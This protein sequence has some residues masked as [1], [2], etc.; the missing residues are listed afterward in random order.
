M[1][2]SGSKFVGLPRGKPKLVA[3]CL[4]GLKLKDIRD[5]RTVVDAKIPLKMLGSYYPYQKKAA[6]KLANTN[7]GVLKSMPRTGKCLSGD[8]LVPTSM[9]MYRLEEIPIDYESINR[10]GK[11]SWASP[12]LFIEVPTINGDKKVSK[13]YKSRANLYEVKTD[14][15]LTINGTEDERLRV[16]DEWIKVNDLEAGNRIKIQTNETSLWRSMDMPYRDLPEQ[17]IKRYGKKIVPRLAT[18]MAYKQKMVAHD[19][20]D[21]YVRIVLNDATTACIR[22]VPGLISGAFDGKCLDNDNEYKI[23]KWLWELMSNLESTDRIPKVIALSSRRIVLTYIKAMYE[24]SGSFSLYRDLRWE[25]KSESLAKEIQVVLLN[26]GIVVK[27]DANVISADST[28]TRKFFIE[29]NVFNREKF[30][31][32]SK[33]GCGD[34]IECEVVSIEK[35]GENDVYDLSIDSDNEDDHNFI[36][37]G[38]VVHNTVMG[39]GAIISCQQKTLVLAHQTDLVEQFCGETLNDPKGKLFNGRR[40]KKKPIAGICKSYSDF[41]KHQ[42]C[43][44][45]Y[46]TFL[47]N[48]GKKL[49]KRIRNMFGIVLVDEVHR[50]PANRYNEI[51]SKFSAKKMWGMTAT[52]DRKDGKYILSE[53]MIG[54]VIHRV[55]APTLQAK[56]MCVESGMVNSR[57]FRNWNTAMNIL[58]S[59][60]KRNNLIAKYA[61]ND[62]KRGHIVLI[63]T[64]R[65]NHAKLLEEK[66]NKLYG[67]KVCFLFTGSISKDDR[68][69]A[70]DAMNYNKKI[71]VCI[72]TRS[73]LTGMNI[74]RWSAIYTVAPTSNEPVYMQEVFRICTPHEG[75]KT[76]IIRYFFDRTMGS[77]S[78]GCF[79]KCKNVLLHP[80]YGFV[81]HDSV[82]QLVKAASDRSPKNRDI[83][84]ID[85]VRT[86]RE[87]PVRI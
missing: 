81:I 70:R 63:P 38:L 30:L 69:K 66:I 79:N 80:E 77:I 14:I 42:I 62:A 82:R 35:Q 67:D 31:H 53:L 56:V 44:A 20:D 9:G 59:N 12:K 5:K 21:G 75:K 64:V 52:D 57:K 54:P 87:S 49:L 43:F 27:R 29:L 4:I 85:A 23:P 24:I 1:N 18:L 36:A 28:N 2:S 41:E 40:Y 83:D 11:E 55:D 51:I 86:V 26:A 32:W 33:E 46:Q 78:Y 10:V 15:G 74:A 17:Y 47:S 8:T 58:F 65:I 61:V 45:T 73:M 37:N 50:T 22:Y 34:V 76:P 84:N 60:E 48:K 19:E 25:A 13:I 68:Q 71:K 39:A 7:G 6:K 3:E 72:A 16:G